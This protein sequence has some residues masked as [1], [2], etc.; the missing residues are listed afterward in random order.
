MKATRQAF[1]MNPQEPWSYSRRVL[2]AVTGLSPQV[3]TET[4]YALAVKPAEG[5]A[6]FVPTEVHIVTTAQG[7]EN[8]RLN[9]LSDQIGWF[10]RLCRDYGLPG[11]AFPADNIHILPGASARPLEDIRTK[12]DN[13]R[14]ADFITDVVRRFTADG[15]AALHVSIAGGRKTM[16]YYIG[17]ALS[18]YGR[19]QDRLSHVLVSEPY[20]NNRDFYYPTPYEHAVHVKREGK[21]VAYDCRNATVDLADI[22]FVRL[23]E[24]LPQRLLD[25]EAT[26]TDI[27]AVANRAERPP[28]LTI[29]LKQRRVL[30]DEQDVDLGS[31]ELAV[32][33][34]LAQRAQKKTAQVDWSTPQAADEFLRV[35]KVVLKSGSGDYDRC[36]EALQWRRNAAIKLAKY[37]EPHKSRINDA[38]EYAV[39]RR[40]AARYAIQRI[41]GKD[42]RQYFLPLS[43]DQIEIRRR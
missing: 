41:S 4:I 24:G 13:E 12:A 39:G 1:R 42:A 16:G 37:F 22:P 20:E 25:G 19:V 23:R 43:P 15:A 34:W 8:A 27:V 26:F 31:I 3:L 5:R 40:G 2:L 14:C 28:R 17:Y 11:I 30:A 18:L 35:A 33:L 10:G 32:L 7:A 29:D 9:L 38:F 36:E 21:D 6:A